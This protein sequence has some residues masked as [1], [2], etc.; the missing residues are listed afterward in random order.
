MEYLSLGVI[1]GSFALDGSVKV[2]SSTDFAPDRYQVG[3]KLYLR[4]EDDI[5]EV[6]VKEY[7]YSGGNDIVSFN[8]INTVEEALA[9]KGYEVLIDKS[10]AILPKNYYHF[11]ELEACEV[12]DN[13]DHYLGKVKKVEE[14]PAQI[15]LR[16]STKEGKQ[17]QVP[18]VEA[19]IKKVDIKN[20]KIVI[21]LIEGML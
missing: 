20:H 9:K 3:N 2:L 16:V 5:V 21:N 17:F 12:F 14:Y 8:E 19:F 13:E 11:Y 7:R 10:E 15:T 6:T 1:I 18:F 4:K